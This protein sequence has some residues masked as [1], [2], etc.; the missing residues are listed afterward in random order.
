MRCTLLFKFK[1]KKNIMQN[2]RCSYSLSQERGLPNRIIVNLNYT[3][4]THNSATLCHE[5]SI[6]WTMPLTSQRWSNHHVFHEIQ[7][8]QSTACYS[9]SMSFSNT[10][11]KHFSIRYLLN[12]SLTILMKT[13]RIVCT[14]TINTYMDCA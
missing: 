1:I 14:L 5:Q 9:I 7:M 13:C 8:R 10:Q 6:N 3:S 11:L 4:H 2:I 12:V